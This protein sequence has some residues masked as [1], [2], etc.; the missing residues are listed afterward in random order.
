MPQVS[1]KLESAEVLDNVDE[2]VGNGFLVELA[3]YRM[4]VADPTGCSGMI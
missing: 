1:L 2:L 4:W 3:D